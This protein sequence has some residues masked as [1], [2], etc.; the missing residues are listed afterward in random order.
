MTVAAT[1]VAKLTAAFAPIALEVIDDSHRHAGHAGASPS[2]E[3]HFNV[4]IVAAAFE[5][6][7]RVARQRAL[8]KALAAELA[9]P[10]H[11]LALEALTPAEA[12]RR[13]MDPR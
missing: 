9:G 2:G 7:S 1:I 8:Y 3:T 13:E 6:Q 12:Q 4:R 11:A 10:V 5:G